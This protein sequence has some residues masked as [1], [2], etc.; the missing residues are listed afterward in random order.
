MYTVSVSDDLAVLVRDAMQAHLSKKDYTLATYR[1]LLDAVQNKLTQLN[2]EQADCTDSE[3]VADKGPDNQEKRNK[4]GAEARTS[5]R[6]SADAASA[7]AVGGIG[8]TGGSVRWTAETL[9]QATWSA[10]MCPAGPD[11][12]AEAKPARKRAKN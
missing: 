3:A 12:S 7:H 4:R 8:A 5:T 11:T 9:E 10:A 1:R 6:A 2:A